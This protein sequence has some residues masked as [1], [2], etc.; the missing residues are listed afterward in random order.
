VVG[1]QPSKKSATKW[2]D[3]SQEKFFRVA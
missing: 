1:W 2:F 3:G